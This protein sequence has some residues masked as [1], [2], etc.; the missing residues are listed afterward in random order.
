MTDNIEMLETIMN[1]SAAS[2]HIDTALE[3]F[4]AYPDAT[5]LLAGELKPMLETLRAVVDLQQ[6]IINKFVDHTL[7][8]DDQLSDFIEKLK[9]E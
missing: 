4:L 5:C 7:E 1:M 2:S 6:K 3:K 8:V 9:S